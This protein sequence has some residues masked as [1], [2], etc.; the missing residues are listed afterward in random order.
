[1]SS[2]GGGRGRWGQA[3]EAET[4]R[5]SVVQSQLM[6]AKLTSRNFPG[7]LTSRLK[8]GP[9]CVEYGQLKPTAAELAGLHS[10]DICGHQ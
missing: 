7:V 9:F 3:S 8:S 1:M 2:W 4:G 10:L 6:A 5:F